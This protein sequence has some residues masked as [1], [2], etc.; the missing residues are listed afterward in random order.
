MTP[1]M[2][3][4]LM[5][6]AYQWLTQFT[7]LTVPVSSSAASADGTKIAACVNNGYIY[8]SSDS[9]ATW[10]EQ[11][12]LGSKRWGSLVINK[13]DC[14]FAIAAMGAVNVFYKYA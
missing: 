11:T 2:T 13:D 8:T 12:A 3:M 10:T 9:G 6:R 1:S 4:T 14:I 7:N 5:K